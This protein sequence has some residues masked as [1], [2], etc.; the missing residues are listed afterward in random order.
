MLKTQGKREETNFDICLCSCAV[1]G[2]P[3]VCHHGLHDS[4]SY[5]KMD[6]TNKVRRFETVCVLAVWGIR[7]NVQTVDS[8]EAVM[9]FRRET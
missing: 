7:R 6:G 9:S 4:R 3:A 8:A 5:S 1:R 2:L